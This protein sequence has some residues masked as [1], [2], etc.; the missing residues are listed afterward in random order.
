MWI[1]GMYYPLYPW[2]FDKAPRWKDTST[3]DKVVSLG[4]VAALVGGIIYLVT[5]RPK[6]P[7]AS[8]PA[9]E[10]FAPPMPMAAPPMPMVAQLSGWGTRC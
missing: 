3:V 8:P 1:G 9:S 6:V 5:K 10:T 4:I 7:A 2:A